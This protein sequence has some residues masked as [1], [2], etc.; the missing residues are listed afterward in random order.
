MPKGITNNPNGRPQGTPN[1]IT[2]EL[3]DTLKKVID[4]ELAELPQ[5]LKALAPLERT[6]LI[7]KLLPYV[8]PKVQTVMPSWGEPFSFDDPL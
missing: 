6:E 8:L 3:R 1:K 7:I 4:G 2:R 5:T